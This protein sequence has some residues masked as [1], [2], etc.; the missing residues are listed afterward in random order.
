MNT[1]GVALLPAYTKYSNVR[2]FIRIGEIS[3]SIYMVNIKYVLVTYPEWG[4][5]APP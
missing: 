2:K 1:R 5:K 4:Q 3:I